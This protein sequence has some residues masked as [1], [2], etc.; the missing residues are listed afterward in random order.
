MVALGYLPPKFWEMAGITNDTFLFHEFHVQKNF[1][2]SQAVGGAKTLDSSA[3]P[4][5]P[6][7]ISCTTNKNPMSLVKP[8]NQT[9][10]QLAWMTF[11]LAQT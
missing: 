6:G 7:G 4:E 5:P 11:H 2:H 10:I 1:L 3:A 9:K 8:D